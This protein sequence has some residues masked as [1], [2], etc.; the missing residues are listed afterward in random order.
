MM[1][2]E[3]N[4]KYANGSACFKIHM[5]NAGVYC[6]DLFYFDGDQELSPPDKIILMRGIRGWRGS[7]DNAALLNNLGMIIDSYLLNV[8]E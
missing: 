4:V 1:N 3:A 5:E 6:A 7:F 8:Q 2:L